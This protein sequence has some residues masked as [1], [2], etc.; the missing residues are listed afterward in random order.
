V[1][2]D[3]RQAAPGAGILGNANGKMG[4]DIIQLERPSFQIVKI[5]KIFLAHLQR[6]GFLGRHDE[7]STR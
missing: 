3:V 7:N 5:H 4:S 1:E 2:R 6:D